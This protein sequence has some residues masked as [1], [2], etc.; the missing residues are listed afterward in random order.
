[1]SRGTVALIVGLFVISLLFIFIVSLLVAISGTLREHAITQAFDLPELMWRSLLR[2]LDPGTMGGDV[3]SVPFV[4]A[5]LTVTLGG[6]FIV[7]TLIGIISTGLQDKLDELRK[8]RSRVLESNHT[9]ILGWSAQI[10]EIIGEI[11]LANSNRRGQCIV[12][13]A[14]RDKIEMEDAIKLRLPQ[15]STTRVVCRSGSPIELADLA[16]AS[17]QTSRSIIVVAPEIE[18]PDNDVIKTLLAITNDPG[19]RE[20]RISDRGRDPRPRGTSRSPAWPAGERLRSCS[21]A[22]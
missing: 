19:R 3:G 9:V 2:T 20:I 8:G 1:M 10:F 16:I 4:V 22:S 13:L 7:A 21:A 17:P 18:D 11:M 6:I 14:D 5:M 15:K 12:V